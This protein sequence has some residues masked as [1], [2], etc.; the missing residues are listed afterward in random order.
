MALNS[1]DYLHC[2]LISVFFF[3]FPDLGIEH[4]A[5]HILGKHCTLNNNHSSLDFGVFIFVF[6]I[7][8][9]VHMGVLLCIHVE[10]SSFTF[11]LTFFIF[12][13]SVVCA[14]ARAQVS[15]CACIDRLF[16]NACGSWK[17]M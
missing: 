2:Q 10:Y 13:L 15:A 17:L 4:T 11:H 12:C 7:G 9:Y 16:W 6:R 8:V 14:C 5:L 1:K 3:F